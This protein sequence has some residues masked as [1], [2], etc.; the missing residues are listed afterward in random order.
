MDLRQLDEA[1]R[2]VL[3]PVVVDYVAGGTGQGISVKANVEA[4]SQEFL[5]PKML[6]DVAKVTTATTVLGTPVPCPV[7]IAPT[8][9]HGLVH[10]DRELATARAAALSDIVYVVSMAATT[11]LE[12]IAQ[13]APGASR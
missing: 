13:A 9:M 1:A 11:S 5:R 3:D 12:D 2:L 6:R 7:L 4:W 10:A 8:A